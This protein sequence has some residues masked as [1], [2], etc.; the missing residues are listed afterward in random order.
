MRETETYDYTV[1]VKYDVSGEGDY[2]EKP[3]RVRASNDKQAMDYA[4][5]YV[6]NNDVKPDIK[7]TYIR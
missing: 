7:E 4:E 1:M 2:Q 5:E 3:V 6:Q